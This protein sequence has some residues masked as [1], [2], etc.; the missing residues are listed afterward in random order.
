[1]IVPMLAAVSLV[2][3]GLQGFTAPSAS[4]HAVPPPPMATPC[5]VRAGQGDYPN[6]LNECAAADPGMVIRGN[7]WYAFTTGLHLYRSTDA[8]HHWDDLGKF[9][10][11]PGGYVDTWAPEVYH[12]AGRWTVYFSMRTARGQY[13]KIYVA[14]SRWLD[15][16]WVLDPT[17]IYSTTDHS[18]IDATMFTDHGRRYLLWKDD[19]QSRE[20]RRISIAQLSQDGRRVV[21][22]PTP[23]MSVT[24]AWE[25]NSIEAPTMLK[26]DGSYY[27]FYSGSLFTYTGGYGVGVAR[28]ASP[29]A[30]F[31]PGKHDGPILTGDDHYASPGHQFITEVNLPGR[32]RTQV[33]FY[34]AYQWY[35][36]AGNKLTSPQTRKLMMD[37][38]HW[39]VDG[40]PT[41]GNGHPSR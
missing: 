24:Q 32:G 10:T 13:E 21:G 15:R 25:N 37:Q 30:N 11:A 28:A 6:P 5:Q 19:Y 34:H 1:M 7:T 27:L 3:A 40:W 39:G 9:L 18:T 14:T 16:G 31:D 22:T 38:L 8:G 41:V 17:P 36:A 35:D 4:A 12:V 23:I 20:R 2:A 33:M 29:T 26:R